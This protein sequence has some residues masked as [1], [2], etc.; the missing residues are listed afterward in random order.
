MLRQLFCYI[1]WVV[2][3]SGFTGIKRILNGYLVG[4]ATQDKSNTLT[5]EIQQ[6]LGSMLSKSYAFRVSR[7]KPCTPVDSMLCCV[8]PVQIAANVEENIQRPL[9]LSGFIAVCQAIVLQ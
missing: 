3:L 9:D 4:F 6:Q 8:V 5:C 7:K 1:V 2:L